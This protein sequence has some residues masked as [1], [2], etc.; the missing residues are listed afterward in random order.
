[1]IATPGLLV[2]FFSLV[3]ASSGSNVRSEPVELILRLF[4]KVQLLDQI[5]VTISFRF[6]QI[7]EQAP[8]LRDHLE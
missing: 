7:I 6:A 4:P 3:M 8:P 5:F 1:V 2:V